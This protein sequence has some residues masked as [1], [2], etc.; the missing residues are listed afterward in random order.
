MTERSSV[1]QGE[2]REEAEAAYHADARVMVKMGYVPASEDWSSEA[3]QVLTVRY[4]YAPEQGWG[5]IERLKEVEAKPAVQIPTA[6][7]S[8]LEES[9]SPSRSPDLK[10]ALG[11][12]AGIALWGLLG[13][14]FLGDNLPVMFV[15]LFALG[16]TGGLIGAMAARGSGGSDGS[17]TS[18]LDGSLNRQHNP[19]GG[20]TR[21]GTALGR[22]PS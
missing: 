6:A 22:R 5:V 13:S 20:R 4:V 15:S 10:V 21:E 17:P 11:A 7:P 19:R 16:L 1:Y 9:P 3:G 14:L 2:T 8:A 12:L 18:E